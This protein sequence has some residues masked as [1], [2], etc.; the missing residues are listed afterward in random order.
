MFLCRCVPCLHYIDIIKPGLQEL[1]AMSFELSHKRHKLPISAVKS[2]QACE[3]LHS[4]GPVDPAS[5]RI[6]AGVL[7]HVWTL[8]CEGVGAVLLSLGDHGCAVCQMVHAADA[9]RRVPLG[10][11]DCSHP[12]AVLAVAYVPAIPCTPVSTTGAGDCMAAGALCALRWGM[13]LVDA[14]CIGAAAA[15]CSCSSVENVPEGLTW[16]AIQGKA[17]AAKVSAAQLLWGVARAHRPAASS[18][19]V[20]QDVGW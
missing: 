2:T 10:V 4:S 18:A 1:Q 20:P 9:R 19:P 14:A 8:L 7:L 12:D 16:G 11:F 3:L 15:H 13:D 5:V 17:E 6:L